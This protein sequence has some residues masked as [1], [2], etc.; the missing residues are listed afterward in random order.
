MQR[1]YFEHKSLLKMPYF[2]IVLVPLPRTWLCP[3]F[4]QYLAAISYKKGVNFEDKRIAHDLPKFWKIMGNTPSSD[5]ISFWVL[6]KAKMPDFL[7]NFRPRPT[8]PILANIW[9]FSCNYLPKGVNFGGKWGAQ[10]SLKFRN[11]DDDLSS[12]DETHF[13]L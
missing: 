9:S 10:D 2:C 12:R 4:G 8:G 1:P 5:Q 13:E 3:K 7:H 6:I 11:I